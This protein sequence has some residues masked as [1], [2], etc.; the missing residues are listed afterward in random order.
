[1]QYIQYAFVCQPFCNQIDLLEFLTFK[2]KNPA[3]AG[4]KKFLLLLFVPER[5]NGIKT[6]CL[7]GGVIAKEYANRHGE[8]NR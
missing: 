3:N 2:K 1:M 4:L 5:L 7:V 6:R 8:A